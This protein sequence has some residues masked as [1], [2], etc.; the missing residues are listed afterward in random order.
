MVERIL[1]KQR[2][3]ALI[4]AQTTNI[5]SMAINMTEFLCNVTASASTTA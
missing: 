2:K 1:T 5:D 4:N 3:T